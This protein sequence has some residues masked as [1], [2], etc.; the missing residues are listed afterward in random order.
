[1]PFLPKETMQV[2]RY[3]RTHYPQ[4][5]SSYGFVDALNPLKSWFDT[6][7]VGIDA[8]IT[9]VMAEN[10]RTGYIWKVFM[11]NP[12]AQRGMQRAGFKTYK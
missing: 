11:E 10:A 5:W 7:V 1:L 2:L 9:M 4:A 8:G 3:I 6:D 12:E